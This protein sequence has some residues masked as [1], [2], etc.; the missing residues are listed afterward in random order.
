MSKTF[1]CTC[2]DVT[3]D[4]VR[5]AIALGHRDIESVK[6][7]TGFGTGPCQGKLCTAA[8]AR[9]L[10]RE[11][12]LAPETLQPFTPRPPARMLSF[13][14]LATYPVDEE[15]PPGE[16]VPVPVEPHERVGEDG[17]PCPHSHP[18]KPME[19]LPAEA[20]VV[21]VGGG[22][23]GL[24]LAYNLAKRGLRDVLVLE[25]GYLCS[26]ASGRNGGGV[27][28]QWSTPTNVRLAR[29]SVEICRAFAREHG[30]NVWFRQGGYL[31]LASDEKTAERLERSAA[32]QNSLGVP[33]R[34]LSPDGAREIVPELATEGFVAASYNPEDGVVFPWPFVWGYAKGARRLGAR[35][36][37]FTKVTG[38]ETGGGRVRAVLT[39]RGTVRC[40]TLVNAAG[41][42]SPGVAKLAGVELPN[43]PHRHEICASE[44]LKP[45]LGPLVSVLDSG[46]YFSQ[47]M[48]GEIVGGMG[49]PKE[50]PRFETGSTL[51]FLARYARAIVR[52]IPRMADVK[53]IRQWAGCYDVTPD[54]NPIL[55]ETPRLP[56]FLQLNGF[57]GH[58]FMMAPAVTELMAIWMTGGPKDEIF[59]RFT[60]DRYERGELVREDF[61]IG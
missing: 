13:G 50:P 49:D 4:D 37:T 56:N 5:Q 15:E 29:R 42:W 26:G 33:T 17:S 41:A 28:M 57:V 20:E 34:L 6:R 30:I 44:P 14:E 25:A 48:R 8:V 35:V 59:D 38:I 23:M 45:W 52:C 46:L 53:V 1:V 2:E 3:I 16:G 31:F 51:R 40:R 55:G 9:I 32:L 27:R 24:A 60:L 61:I 43:R 19:P 18:L 7:F 10:A 36:E 47:S 54:N 22:I 12:G 21:I 39:D 11:A 58:G